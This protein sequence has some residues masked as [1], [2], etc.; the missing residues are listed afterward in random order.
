MCVCGVCVCGVCVFNVCVCVYIYTPVKF[1]MV[2]YNYFK[3]T[4][5]ACGTAESVDFCCQL[6]VAT[7]K[8]ERRRSRGLQNFLISLHFIPLINT[9]YPCSSD[10]ELTS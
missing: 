8:E 2:G 1:N 3:S 9:E 4:L 10:V 7:P 5:V 6:Q